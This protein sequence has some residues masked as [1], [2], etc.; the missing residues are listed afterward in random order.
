[1]LGCYAQRLKSVE[2][3]NSFYRLPTP[4]AVKSWVQQTPADFCFAL[5]ASRYITHIRKLLRPK[6]TTVKFLDVADLFGQKLGPILF[7]FPQIW[8]RN[9]LRLAEFLAALPVKHRYAFEFRNPSW[10]APAI[11]KL[12]AQFNAAFCIFEIGGFQSPVQTTADFVY[13]R[14]H[15]PGKAYQGQYTS[16]ALEGWATKIETWTKE[17]RKVFFYFD[18]DQAGYAAQD[19][20]QL[21]QLVGLHSSPD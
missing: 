14:L 12:L 2:V 19:A 13:V 7:Q 4:S 3:N 8:Q 5:K 16:S 18:N 20:M 10:H 17:H 9:E 21:T 15:G 6:E 11:Y 1:M